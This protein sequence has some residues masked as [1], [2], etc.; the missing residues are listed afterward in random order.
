VI[1]GLI[2]DLLV[3]LAGGIG[4]LGLLQGLFG[5]RTLV[6]PYAEP[7][8]DDVGGGSVPDGQEPFIP[9]PDHVTSHAEMVAWMTQDLPRLAAEAATKPL[10]G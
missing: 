5:S 9:M 4:M 1:A 2:L 8:R 10:G 6:V 7:V 3:I